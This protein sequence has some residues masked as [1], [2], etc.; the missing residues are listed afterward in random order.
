[1]RTD[2]G[3]DASSLKLSLG[4]T[5][6]ELLTRLQE[7]KTIS[8][9]AADQNIPEEEVVE[10][11]IDPYWDELQ[12]R[13]K[14][15]YIT[16]EQADALLEGARDHARALLSQDLSKSGKRWQGLALT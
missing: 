4:L 13:V 16:Q 10:A 14:C 6:D 15:S 7:G 9:I 2:E 11:I 12:L 3:Y 8:E 1:M 5:Q